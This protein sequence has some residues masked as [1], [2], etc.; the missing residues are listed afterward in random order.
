MSVW[1]AIMMRSNTTDEY[2]L[3][4]YKQQ[5]YSELYPI[6]RQPQWWKRQARVKMTLQENAGPLLTAEARD[7]LNHKRQS[8]GP[9]YGVCCSPGQ[10]TNRPWVAE[11]SR[12]RVQAFD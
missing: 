10:A 12:S 3:N 9:R 1:H 6:S 8:M 5:L 4:S 11:M 2:V 7:S